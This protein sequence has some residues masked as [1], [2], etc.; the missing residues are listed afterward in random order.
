MIKSCPYLSIWWIVAWLPI[1]LLF[2]IGFG[3]VRTHRAL[4]CT[5]VMNSKLPA[6]SNS[7]M[8]SNFKIPVLLLIIKVYFQYWRQSSEHIFNNSRPLAGNIYRDSEFANKSLIAN[9]ET[10]S[11]NPSIDDKWWL[12]CPGIIVW[13]IFPHIADINRMI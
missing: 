4:I 1:F 3:S 6:K 9:T 10:N 2:W 11:F 5:N 13:N 8:V 12:L 7:L